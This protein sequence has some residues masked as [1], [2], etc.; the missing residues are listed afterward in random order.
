MSDQKEKD[1]FEK[2]DD[3]FENQDIK[4]HGK[5]DQRTDNKGFKDIEKD[6]NQQKPPLD[7]QS[8]R[9]LFWMIVTIFIVFVILPFRLTVDMGFG[10]P[11][12]FMFIIIVIVVSTL[13]KNINKR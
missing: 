8:Y 1:P 6:P 10:F 2:Y 7:S 4:Y 11:P 13:I 5:P 3:L 9:K 12:I